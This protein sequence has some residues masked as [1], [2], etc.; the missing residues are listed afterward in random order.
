[1]HPN[2]MLDYGNKII[3]AFWDGTFQS[4]HLKKSGDAAYDYV[5]KDVNNFIQEMK[6]RWKQKNCSRDKRQN[7]RCKR[8][9]KKN[10]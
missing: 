10:E 1:M 9:N 8:Q 5:L 7:I 2:D 4:E 3:E 6:S